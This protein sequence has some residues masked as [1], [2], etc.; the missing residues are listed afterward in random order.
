[1]YSI[2]S[3]GIG[4]LLVAFIAWG[5]IVFFFPHTNIDSAF[6]AIIIF[7][8]LGGI[9]GFLLCLKITQKVNKPKTT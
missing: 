2:F 5:I 9:A 6:T 4:A 7:L 3:A 1:M 8:L